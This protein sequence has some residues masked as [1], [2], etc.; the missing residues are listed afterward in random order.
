[1][2]LVEQ[3]CERGKG[4]MC[5]PMSLEFLLNPESLSKHCAGD[6]QTLF[7]FLICNSPGDRMYFTC[8]PLARV[9]RAPAVVRDRC[10]LFHGKRLSQI[11]SE[12]YAGAN[13]ESCEYLP[14]N[15]FDDIVNAWASISVNCPAP[16][17]T[18]SAVMTQAQW[19]AHA[20]N[21]RP[22]PYNGDPGSLL[23]S[24]LG[25]SPTATRRLT[26]REDPGIAMIFH[27]A[28]DDAFIPVE[29]TQLHQAFPPE[30]EDVPSTMGRFVD[31]GTRAMLVGMLTGGVVAA[32]LRKPAACGQAIFSAC[33]LP[34]S[35]VW[36]IGVTVVLVMVTLCMLRDI[37]AA[38]ELQALSSTRVK[39]TM[40]PE[41]PQW[42]ILHS[43]I[44]V[45][46][47]VWRVAQCVLSSR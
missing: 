36:D 27:V 46:G 7:T 33:S 19:D 11:I 3:G 14:I 15:I 37:H 17:P 10:I 41:P 31:F 9:Q 28:P 1:M 18:A 23:S 39:M 8:T 45:A 25:G 26:G 38:Q 47:A 12:P 21:D 42:P 4:E 20:C 5:D 2:S 22:V 44:V 6:A 43:L 35:Q 13:G 29:T 32:F 24:P 30:A 34:S 16:Y 40:V